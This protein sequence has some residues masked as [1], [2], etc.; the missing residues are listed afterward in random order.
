VSRGM[1]GTRSAGM[2][3]ERAGVRTLVLTHVNAHLDS[4]AG[5]EE[6]L[7]EVA[8]VFDGQV[9]FGEELLSL[10]VLA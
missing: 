6:G 4:P 3:A 9:V 10:D 1:T 2:L 5:R 7:R 8:S